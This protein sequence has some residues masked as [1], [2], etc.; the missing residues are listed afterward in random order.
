[1]E[2]GGGRCGVETTSQTREVFIALASLIRAG[3]G[4]MALAILGNEL[5]LIVV[6][7]Y[8]KPP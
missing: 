3:R 7:T 4:E 5:E 2:Q 1:M 8:S 6:R